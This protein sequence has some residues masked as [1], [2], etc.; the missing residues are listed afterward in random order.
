MFSI[1]PV[2]SPKGIILDEWSE[3]II[4]QLINVLNYL[5]LVSFLISIYYLTHKSLNGRNLYNLRSIFSN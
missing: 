3:E 2:I 5:F 1:R 4:T